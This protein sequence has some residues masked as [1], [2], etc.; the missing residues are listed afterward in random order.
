MDRSI[1]EEVEKTYKILHSG[2]VIL[3]PT[4]TVW[5]QGCDALNARAIDRVYKIKKRKAEKSMIILLDDLERVSD[6]VTFIP[7]ILP[8]LIENFDRPLTVI[9]DKGKN[10]PKNLLADD[11]SIAIRIVKDEFC[12]PLIKRLGRP[13][14]STSANVSG[15][16]AP[17]IFSHISSKIR[18]QVDYTVELFRD[19]LGLSKTSTIIRLHNDGNYEVVRE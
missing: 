1:I 17:L 4:D 9:Y 16:P 5:G 7:E 2:G 6:Y 19:R 15:E 8:D 18:D 11:G 12:R 3:Y 13:L 14:I 10:L